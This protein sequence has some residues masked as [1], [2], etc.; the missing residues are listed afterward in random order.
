M[1][2]NQNTQKEAAPYS[3]LDRHER[4]LDALVKTKPESED[5]NKKFKSDADIKTHGKLLAHYDITVYYY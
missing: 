2:K 4:Y 5:R 3:P 1:N